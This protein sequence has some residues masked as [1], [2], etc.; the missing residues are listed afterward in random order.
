MAM[1][2]Q[3]KCSIF[4]IYWIES[5]CREE[6]HQKPINKR[7]SIL[8]W[9]SIWSLTKVWIAFKQL[10][11]FH[12]RIFLYLNV[13]VVDV[14]VVI[15]LALNCWQVM[16]VTVTLSFQEPSHGWLATPPRPE[17]LISLSS[18]S[19]TVRSQLA[20]LGRGRVRSLLKISSPRCSS[21][22]SLSRRSVNSNI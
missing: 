11:I 3:R 22:K 18:C 10:I 2:D 13:V 14:V 15:F 16:R 6:E 1:H 8:I 17:I 21:R 5:L 19:S 7:V 20:Y 9:P 4:I 12:L